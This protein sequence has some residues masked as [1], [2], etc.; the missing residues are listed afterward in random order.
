MGDRARQHSQKIIQ[1]V[2]ILRN[3]IIWAITTRYAIEFFKTLSIAHYL[4]LH[5]LRILILY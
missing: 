2:L 1:R 4:Y 3:I 5:Y